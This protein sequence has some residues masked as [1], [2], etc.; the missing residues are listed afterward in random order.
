MPPRSWGWW[1]EQKLDVL[2]DYLA[3]FT[4]AS[5]KA[6]TTVYL[7]LFAGQ[8]NKI[9]RSR[10]E[11]PIRGSARRALDTQPRFTVLRFFELASKASILDT[12]LKAEYPGRDF[13]V[14]SGDCNTMIDAVLNDLSE[15]N[16]A[17]TFA[18]LDQQSTEVQ[19]P[20]LQRLARHK[21]ADKPKTEMWLLCAS[22]LLP[23]GLRIRADAIDTSVADK[24][25]G[26]FGTDIWAEALTATRDNPHV[27]HPVPRRADKPHALAAGAGPRI[28]NNPGIPGHQPPRSRNL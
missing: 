13:R 20:T 27:R 2:A 28:Q 4:K 9:S 11:H 24:V 8:A 21:R 5:T 6:K 1:T 3:S 17:P 10:D 23:R 25:T 7:D 15:L 19:W 22:G 12:A 26:M 16:W 18:F 14:V